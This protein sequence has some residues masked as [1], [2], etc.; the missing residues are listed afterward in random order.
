MLSARE[1]RDHVRLA[2]QTSLRGD[3]AVTVPQDVLAAGGGFTAHVHA[4]RML[5]PLIREIVLDLPEDQPFDFRAGEF[6]QIT[7]PR[8]TLDFATLDLPPQ[9]RAVWE[10]VGLGRVAHPLGRGRDPGLFR[11]QPPRGSREGR[12]QHPPR[13]AAPGAGGQHSARSRVVLA[14]FRPAGRSGGRVRPLRRLPCPAHRA[15]N[16]LCRWRRRHGAPARD[17]PS[18]AWARVDPAHPLFLRRAFCRRSLL[19]GRI[20]RSRG[21]RIRISASR[22]PCPIRHPATAGPGR[23]AL[24]TKRCGATCS[25]IR[26]R[27][28]ANTISAARR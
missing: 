25:P 14:L 27:R 23:P 16:G 12:V 9:Y 6:M 2:C 22:Q 21:A 4:A 19:S 17:D 3:C 7:A 13:R 1:R 10:I 26:R 11:R 8:F 15:R 24:S 20:R 28:S 5:A 18:G